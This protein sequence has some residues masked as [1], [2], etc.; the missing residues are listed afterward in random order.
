[1]L[2]LGAGNHIGGR[3]KGVLYAGP[4][5]TKGAKVSYLKRLDLQALTHS[6]AQEID[7][8]VGLDEYEVIH[9]SAFV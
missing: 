7:L 2:K 5:G 6:L 8:L 3:A 9:D 4:H 1:L